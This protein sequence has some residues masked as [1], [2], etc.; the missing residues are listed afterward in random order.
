MVNVPVAEADPAGVSW[1][2]SEK[3][4]DAGENVREPFIIR[5]VA[6]DNVAEGGGPAVGW[7]NGDRTTAIC[8]IYGAD[9]VSEIFVNEPGAS[10]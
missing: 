4:A 3:L 8:P 10:P 5:T 6:A 9:G 1:S 2:C 7:K